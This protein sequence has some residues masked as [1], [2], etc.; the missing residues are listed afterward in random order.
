LTSKGSWQ[1]VKFDEICENVS[2]R[3]DDPQNSE[4]EKFVGL[5]HLDTLE[6]KIT[7]FGS[8]DDVTSTMT[9]FKNEQILFG[10]RN[11]YLRRVAVADFDGLCSGDIYVLEAIEG[12]IIKDF[13]PLLMH[14]DEFFE[15]NMMYSHGSMSTRVKWSNLAKMEFL[16]PSIP[17]QENILFIIQKIDNT[18]TNSQNLIEKTR[19][20]IISR[21]E[22]ILSRGINHTKFRK[23]FWYDKKQIE[24]PESWKVIKF[25]DISKIKRGA[26]PRPISNKKYFGNGRGWIRI[27][28]VTKSQM[29]LEQTKDYLSKL[30][31]S[32]S[33]SV[34]P[35]DV[36]MS[37]AATLAVPIILKMKACIHD[38]FVL[39]SNVSEKIDKKFLYYT[40]LHN[41]T[42]FLN[43]R[44][45]GTQSNLNSTIVGDS[46]LLLP[47]LDEQNVI[48]SIFDNYYEMIIRQQSHLT[49]LKILRQSVLNSKLTKEKNVPN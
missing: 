48:V 43:Q 14:S 29:Y 44:Q 21:R 13:L 5:E 12:K 32:K 4:Y 33:V 19:N 7:R 6:P 41:K 15:R 20:Y 31:E 3:V 36:I 34:N 9:L 40:L 42:Q 23:I 18:I 22:L 28:D 24:I 17:E 38:G 8:T 16:I 46:V 37:I 30:G 45:T 27:K 47:P 25:K 1:K 39:F 35:G 26:S 49:N 2:K 10:R 11:W